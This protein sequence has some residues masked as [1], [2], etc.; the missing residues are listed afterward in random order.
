MKAS[1][2]T[3]ASFVLFAISS[4][5]Q[6][7]SNYYYDYK[8]LNPAF[9]GNQ[10]K[11]VI[12]TAYSGFPSIDYMS[13]FYGSY[14]TSIPKIKSGIGAMGYYSN[15]GVLNYQ[16]AGIFYS[17]QLPFNEHSGLRA[18]TLLHYR[19][20]E[21]DYDRDAGFYDVSVNGRVTTGLNLDFGVL[22]Y[23]RVL[24]IGVGVNDF[25]KQGE[26]SNTRW[27]LSVSRDFKVANALEISPSIVVVWDKFARQYRFDVNTII[28]IKQ[29]IILGAGY[30]VS[31][32]YDGVNVSAGI[33]VKDWVQ[34]I[35]HVYSS[36]NDYFRE[37]NDGQV[38]V[39][40]RANI[41]HREKKSE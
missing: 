29:W 21:A 11:H 10:D 37:Y 36:S 25:F 1:L 31:D 41:P 14:E 32:D 34:V 17:K 22:Y 39:I 8:L 20:R 26:V 7:F 6:L 35:G 9:A 33:N 28:E 40:V 16:A 15:R 12:T 3:L 27:N 30:Y 18:G 38:E 19:K 4:Q 24:N 23:S 13:M 5:A 2:L